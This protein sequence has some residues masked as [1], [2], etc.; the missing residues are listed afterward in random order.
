MTGN[1]TNWCSSCEAQDIKALGGVGL[2]PWCHQYTDWPSV[3]SVRWG[4]CAGPKR[5]WETTSTP[6]TACLARCHLARATE[7]STADPPD[8]SY[9]SKFLPYI[10]VFTSSYSTRTKLAEISWIWI[11]LSW[12]SQSIEF[13]PIHPLTKSQAG[14]QLSITVFWVLEMQVPKA[15]CM[16]RYCHVLIIASL[17]RSLHNKSL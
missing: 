2:K 14:V 10:Y 16:L 7:A 5:Y 4:V 6:P 12:W 8:Y 3:I 13:L 9:E 1:L 15:Y 17:F 11:L